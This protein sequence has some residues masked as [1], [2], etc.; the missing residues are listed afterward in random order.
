MVEWSVRKKVDQMAEWKALHLVVTMD[1]ERV[2]K[3]DLKKVGWK[4]LRKVV[5]SASQTVA[6]RAECLDAQMAAN[7]VVKTVAWK[8]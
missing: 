8:A 3:M 2:G 6:L 7:S 1:C 4:E 5:S